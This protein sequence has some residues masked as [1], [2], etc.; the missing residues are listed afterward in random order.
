MSPPIKKYEWPLGVPCLNYQLS[1]TSPE[2]LCNS[3]NSLPWLDYKFVTVQVCFISMWKN[4]L[5][6]KFEKQMYCILAVFKNASSPFV[7]HHQGRSL[8]LIH[9]L[10]CWWSVWWTVFKWGTPVMAPCARRSLELGWLEMNSGNRITLTSYL[11]MGFLL[12]FAILDH[13][14]GLSS[15]QFHVS[16]SISTSTW[17]R[18]VPRLWEHCELL[19]LSG[20]VRIKY[21]SYRISFLFLWTLLVLINLFLC[22]C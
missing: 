18:A 9:L 1:L 20:N 11:K 8:E 5:Q 16:S 17:C 12:G 6:I 14:P 10:S 4:C 21:L 22:W 3:P 2:S 13:V 15:S 7:K 19:R